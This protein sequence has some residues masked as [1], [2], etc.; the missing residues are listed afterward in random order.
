MLHDVTCDN[1]GATSAGDA[2]VCPYCKTLLVP[3]PA[4]ASPSAPA[5]TA[6]A[7]PAAA[8]PIGDWSKVAALYREGQ[9]DKALAQLAQVVKAHPNLFDDPEAAL[10]NVKLLLESEGSVARMRQLLEP[11][12][13]Q[14]PTPPRHGEYKDVIEAKAILDSGARGPAEAKLRSLVG[15]FPKNEHALLLFGTHLFW[16][17]GD[18]DLACRHLEACVAIRPVMLRAWACLGAVYSSQGREQVAAEAF[19]KCLELETHPKMIA[20]FQSFLKK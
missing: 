1:C 19:R 17:K 20:Y 11:G 14:S 7:K 16:S 8:G 2:T 10:L 12:L 6:T 18:L 15:R 4:P 13:R 3:A 9:V 5:A